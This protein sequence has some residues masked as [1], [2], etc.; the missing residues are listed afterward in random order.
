MSCKGSDAEKQVAELDIAIGFSV[1]YMI[2]CHGSQCL[3]FTL[4]V[5]LARR[6][7]STGISI[8]KQ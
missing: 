6:T 4:I 3:L 5:K 8:S 2:R 7:A 1:L